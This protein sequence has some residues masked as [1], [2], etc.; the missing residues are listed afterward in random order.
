MLLIQVLFLIVALVCFVI[1]MFEVRPSPLRFIAAGLVFVVLDM[2]TP[3][4]LSAVAR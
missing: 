3:A 2:L 1:A 4:L